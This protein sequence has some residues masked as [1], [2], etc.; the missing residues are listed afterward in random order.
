MSINKPPI[1]PFIKPLERFVEDL[2]ILLQTDKLSL[3]RNFCGDVY[4]SSS[5]SDKPPFRFNLN[6]A[7]CKAYLMQILVTRFSIVPTGSDLSALIVYLRGYAI[8]LQHQDP[9]NADLQNLLLKNEWISVVEAYVDENIHLSGLAA[10]C[11]QKLVDYVAAKPGLK[12]VRI[13]KTPN[14]FGRMLRH[15]EQVFNELGLVLNFKDVSE[16]CQLT[17]EREQASLSIPQTTDNNTMTIT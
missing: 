5:S 16:G 11:L 4:L 3:T 8:S 10:S 15:Y 17:I 9:L 7:D 12:S 2:R 14:N 1:Q 13:P 6:T